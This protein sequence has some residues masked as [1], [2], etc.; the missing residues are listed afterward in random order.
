MLPI[1]YVYADLVMAV[2]QIRTIKSIPEQDKK[3]NPIRGDVKL[4]LHQMGKSYLVYAEYP[5]EDPDYVDPAVEPE[6]EEEVLVE[7]ETKEEIPTE[8]PVEEPTEEEVTE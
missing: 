7:E 5:E 8:E 1:V 6:K 2:P 3:G 4:L